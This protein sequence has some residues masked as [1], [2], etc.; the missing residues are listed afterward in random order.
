MN[1]VF[2]FFDFVTV[3]NDL[4]VKFWCLSVSVLQI[5]TVAMV[6]NFEVMSDT[7]ITFIIYM[8]QQ[9]L[10][11]EIYIRHY[12]SNNVMTL[13]SLLQNRE[14]KVYLFMIEFISDLRSRNLSSYS[15][16]CLFCSL[17]FFPTSALSF[18]VLSSGIIRS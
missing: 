6:Q 5:S 18:L 12:G 7:F 15:F 17:Y 8:K 14:Q 2:N 11:T 1:F 16:V 13:I 4:N 3:T 10:C 9:K